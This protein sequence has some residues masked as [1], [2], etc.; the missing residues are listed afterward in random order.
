MPFFPSLPADAGLPQVLALNRGARRAVIS[1]HTAMFAVTSTMS[2]TEKELIAAYVS[3]L[4]ARLRAK[5]ACPPAV[6][7]GGTEPC[8]VDTLLE[9]FDNAPVDRRLRPILAYARKLAMTPLLIT[10]ADANAVF[11]EGWTERDLHDTVL[12]AA[13]FVYLNCLQDGHG[14]SGVP[15]LFDGPDRVSMSFDCAM[16]LK[17]LE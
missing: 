15:T 1:A 14:V 13:M 6:R 2:A 5:V 10:A 12:V 11:C 9:N 8:L 17:W 4:I 3:A 16:P 7:E